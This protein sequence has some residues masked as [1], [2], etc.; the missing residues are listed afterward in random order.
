MYVEGPNGQRYDV[1]PDPRL[2]IHQ[3]LQLACNHWNLSPLQHVL[4]LQ[5]KLL[6]D[7]GLPVRLA[8]IATG[9]LELVPLE[10]LGPKELLQVKA[11]REA[12]LSVSLSLVETGVKLAPKRLPGTTRLL[13]MIKTFDPGLVQT[14]PIVRLPVIKAGEVVVSGLRA[15]QETSLWML[16]GWQGPFEVHLHETEEDPEAIRAAMLEPIAKRADT[17]AITANTVPNLSLPLEEDYDIDMV[18]TEPSGQTPTL[19][20]DLP[21]SFYTLSANELKLFQSKASHALRQLQ[22]RPLLSKAALDRKHTE[23]L[24][25]SHPFSRIRFRFPDGVCVERNFRTED[26]VQ[27]MHHWLQATM[28]SGR[29]LQFKLAIGP[30]LRVLGPQE[31]ILSLALYPAAIVNVIWEEHEAR[32]RTLNVLAASNNDQEVQPA[33]KRITS[34]PPTNMNTTG[35]PKWFRPSK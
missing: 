19:A 28:A 35:M 32:P 7:P 14:E 33:A 8:G 25:K 21:D 4:R 23:A 24:L 15:L 3:L 18:I 12:P 10:V 27:R 16:G 13:A 9:H 17:T 29:L 34:P 26:S 20:P 5:R 1:Q 22:D 31:S 11:S 2:T 6:L 30:P